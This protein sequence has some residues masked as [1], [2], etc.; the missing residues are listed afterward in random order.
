[1]KTSFYDPDSGAW[2]IP[3]YFNIAE[4]CVDLNDRPQLSDKT[5]FI[6][7]NEDASSDFIDYQSL[8]CRVRQFASALQAL[9]V[10]PASRVL[11]RLPNCIDYPV[12][13]LGALYAGC[14]AVPSSTLL[15]MDEVQY[16]AKDS[17]AELLVVCDSM[18]DQLGD[19]LSRESSIKQVLVVKTGE[20]RPVLP[21]LPSTAI[22]W[23]DI[24][25]GA[26]SPAKESAFTRADDPAYLVYTSGTTGYPKG[27][28]HAHRALIGRVPASH[29]WFDF[30]E[31]GDRILH[32]GKF[33]WTY[34]LGTALMDPLFQGKTVI[35]YEGTGSPELW[36]SLIAKHQCSIFIGVPTIYRQILQKTDFADKD[37]PSLKHCMCAGE[38]LS[39]EIL[40]HWQGRFGVEIF[41]ALGMSECSYYLSHPPGRSLKPG[42]AGL[43]QP[44]HNV[45]LLDASANPVA[46][47]EEGMLCIPESDPGL[48]IEYWKLKDETAKSRSQGFFM[49]GDFARQDHEGYLWFLG[50]KDDIINSFGYRISPIE[51][52][53]VLKSHEA[54]IDSV[55]MQECVGKDKE[56]VSAFVILDKAWEK[57]CEARTD[58]I[59]HITSYAKAHLAAYKVPKMVRIVS[60]FPRTRN[61]K[62]LRK[63][64][65]KQISG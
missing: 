49:T 41:E 10:G 19:L 52:E 26:H 40:S 37:V 45:L 36:P 54:V 47:G 30:N 29:F 51:V 55:V 39:D 2:N 53:R 20:E 58:Q 24:L 57:A 59:E 7:E 50:R 61:G 56:I 48:F 13:F 5:A 62:V 63:E 64:L 3:E 23:L 31:G 21:I 12:V 60:E 35:V 34:V 17:D 18:L 32:S 65:E 1:M 43:P 38:H 33:N 44:G 9:S 14:I 15:T 4:A 27:V 46:E 16:L 11:I 42:S 22:Q 25:I 6:V 28:L 8:N